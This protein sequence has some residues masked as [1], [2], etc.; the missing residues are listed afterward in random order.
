MTKPLQQL[1]ITQLMGRGAETLIVPDTTTAAPLLC[2]SIL[3]IPAR[4]RG[5]LSYGNARAALRAQRAGI[6]AHRL[7]FA[8]TPG[9]L[10]LCRK[11]PL[12]V[13][14][15]RIVLLRSCAVSAGRSAP[16][17]ARGVRVSARSFA[18][19]GGRGRSDSRGNGT[20]GALGN[21]VRALWRPPGAGAGGRGARSLFGNSAR[22]SSTS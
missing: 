9:E 18:R 11:Q 16:G 15:K 7:D 2:V 4:R 10:T 20:D 5:Q 22:L 17:A 6:V 14:A 8:D 19:L 13:Q 1:R 3:C 21:G 12:A